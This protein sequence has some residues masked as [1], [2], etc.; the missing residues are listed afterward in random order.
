MIKIKDSKISKINY[1]NISIAKVYY[2]KQLIFQKS[3]PEEYTFVDQVLTDTW[4]FSDGN[5]WIITFIPQSEGKPK[6]IITDTAAS[7]SYIAQPTDYDKDI[8]TQLTFYVTG[9][10]D[11]A[12]SAYREYTPAH[13]EDADGNW[14]KGSWSAWDDQYDNDVSSGSSTVKVGTTKFYQFVD[15]GDGTFTWTDNTLFT[16]TTAKNDN[17]IYQQDMF[18]DI[19]VATRTWTIA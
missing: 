12:F 3:T 10:T 4:H 7:T 11:Y 19:Y 13:W 16:G 5:N 2:G 1:G 9:S 18:G 17:L 15:N 8:D 14:V 6:Y